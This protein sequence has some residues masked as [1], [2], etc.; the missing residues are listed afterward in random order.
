MSAMNDLILD[1]KPS[2]S[3]PKKEQCRGSI[4]SALSP[5]PVTPSSSRSEQRRGTSHRDQQKE[6]EKE[7]TDDPIRWPIN[8]L[9]YEEVKPHELVAIEKLF[10]ARDDTPVLMKWVLLHKGGKFHKRLVVISAFRMWMLQRKKPFKTQLVSCNE[11][12]LMHIQKIKVLSGTSSSTT[13]SSAPTTSIQLFI[14]QRQFG[15]PPLVLHFDPGVHTESFIRLLQRLLHGLRL[16]FPDKQFPKVQLP[17]QCHWEEFFAS[18]SSDTNQEE[19]TTLFEA[20]TTAYRAF[21]DDLDLRYRS[22]ITERLVECAGSYVDF[23]YCLG[24]PPGVDGY[25]QQPSSIRRHLGISSSVSSSSIQ[26]REVQ[27]LARTLEHAHCFAGIVVYDLSMNEIGMSALFQAL[28]SP[29]SSINAFTLTNINLSARSLRILQHVVLQSTIKRGQQQSLQL[30]RLDFSFNTFSQA[31]AAELATMFELLPS[32]LEILQLEQCRLS[33]SSNSR[34]L[35]AMKTN[36]AFSSCLRELNLSGNHLSQESTRVLSSWIT[37]AFALHRLDVSRTKL[38]LNVFFQA[39]RQNSILHESS[40]RVL[41]LSYNH[42]RAQASKDLGWILGKTQSLATLFLR[43]M[44]RRFHPRTLVT[45][46]LARLAKQASAIEVHIARSH[47]TKGLTKLHLKNILAPM[48]QNTGRALPCLLDLSEND[49]R[50]R[51]AGILAQLI[52]ES[53]FASRASLRLDHTCL[54]DKP[55]RSPSAS[56]QN[57]DQVT[58]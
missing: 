5:T 31:M 6:D 15:Q 4:P 16:V 46:S 32:G 10:V 38:D 1:P 54:H 55:V 27:A 13:S 12:Q 42:M 23:Q 7:S 41:D 2:P 51:E 33:S 25:Q 34:I 22:S 18:S 21:C 47:P 57:S 56:A 8:R 20:M 39:L 48:F 43:G 11:L 9:S 53:P 45:Q 36:T 52:D 28:L 24:F 58:H 44:Q 29:Y 35:L 3:S 49:L 14:S 17:P 30:R 19:R 40:L 26:L 37:G 50:G